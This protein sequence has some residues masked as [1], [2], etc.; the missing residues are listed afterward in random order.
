[1]WKAQ[2][3]CC[4]II[5][6]T[7]LQ[8]HILYPSHLERLLPNLLLVLSS[9]THHSPMVSPTSPIRGFVLVTLLTLVWSRTY[10]SQELP[11][12]QKDPSNICKRGRKSAVCDPDG[13]LS[14]SDADTL[15]GLANFIS[16]GTNGFKQALS[17]PSG[18]VGAQLAIAVFDSMSDTSISDKKQRAF[19]FAKDLHDRWGVGDAECQNGIVIVLSVQDHAM[20]FSIGAGAKT[21]FTDE[22]LPRVM[23][24]MKPK[25]R[26]AA[27]GAALIIGVTSVGNIVSGAALPKPQGDSMGWLWF[28]QIS[29]V[30]A[31]LGCCSCVSRRKRGRYQK[32]K[33]LLEKMDHDRA[34][35]SQN[36][37]MATS[38]PI[39]LEDFPDG[40]KDGKKNGEG[41]PGE[42]SV[43]VN[44]GEGDGQVRTLRAGMKA[45]SGS[46]TEVADE[47]RLRTLPC[48][49]KFHEKC[50]VTWFSGNRES[51]RQCPICRQSIIDG[52]AG[53]NR[54]DYSQPGGWDVYDPEYSFRMRRT[55]YYYPDFV[56]WSM[57]NSWE[58]D[59]YDAN[60]PMAN[61]ST[62]VA[63]DPVVVAAAARASGS[64]G[65]SFSF[66]G[67]SSAGGG[68]GGG[69]W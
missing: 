1:M 26:E 32:C 37:Y 68:G 58:R 28:L 17:C 67:G 56:T 35:A 11:S 30:L 57:I 9:P 45:N 14:E 39:C 23:D 25:L 27:Y 8:L 29:S 42:E 21:R 34:Q 44:V 5:T 3:S 60:R 36:E 59:R 65:S 22:L 2:K 61:C 20:G 66:G 53:E 4:A 33:V 62:F 49:H 43:T 69:S 48:G 18:P 19:Q 7:V 12:P 63:V 31:V 16:G 13:L 47:G 15:D 6:Y 64:G 52:S 40:K 55:Q 50:V 46:R 24:S 10:T 38:C 54:T 51:N 41:E